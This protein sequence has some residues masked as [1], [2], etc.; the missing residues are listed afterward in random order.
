M[1]YD[2]INGIS[3]EGIVE[4]IN[5]KIREGWRPLGDISVCPENDHDTNKPTG[6][7][8]YSQAIVKAGEGVLDA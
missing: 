4:R 7:M 3:H 8:L 2:A 5:A 1:K 6:H